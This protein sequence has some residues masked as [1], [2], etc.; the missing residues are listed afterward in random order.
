[1]RFTISST[2]R[3]NASSCSSNRISAGLTGVESRIG[4]RAPDASRQPSFSRRSSRSPFSAAA[5]SLGAQRVARSG[6]GAQHSPRRCPHFLLLQI[7]S[8][9][10][11]TPSLRL[12]SGRIGPSFRQ[13]AITRWTDALGSPPPAS[14]NNL[15]CPSNDGRYGVTG[16]GA[17]MPIDGLSESALEP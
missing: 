1:M 5:A 7:D 9:S 12:Q 2:C 13:P 14:A 3:P 6:S 4:L 17:N 10:C 11:F 8:C 16:W 15:A